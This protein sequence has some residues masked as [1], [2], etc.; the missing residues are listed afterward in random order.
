M[1]HLEGESHL[2]FREQIKNLVER[3]P[4]CVCVWFLSYDEHIHGW[5]FNVHRRSISYTYSYNL[6]SACN[7]YL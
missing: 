7:H 4:V 3:Q 5:Y 1:L 2:I 6:S